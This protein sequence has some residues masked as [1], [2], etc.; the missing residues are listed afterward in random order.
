MSFDNLEQDISSLIDLDAE[1]DYWDFKEKWHD[2]NAD[3]L[4]DI[5]CMA[6]NL[7]NRDAYIIIGVTDPPNCQVT[8]VPS[9]NRKTQQNIIDFLKDV[10]FIGGVRP[11]V[12]VVAIEFRGTLIDV[13]IV[14]NTVMY[15][16]S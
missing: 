5:I 9:A 12:Y 7:A 1:G 8:G 13:I 2:N 6:N 14:K 4:H 3:L 11:T 15:P 10:K 16:S